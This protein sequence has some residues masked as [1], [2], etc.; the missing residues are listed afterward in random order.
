MDVNELI[1]RANSGDVE[2]EAE[3][4]RQFALKGDFAASIQWNQRAAS[5]GSG[6]AMLAL[7]SLYSNGNGVSAD[8]NEANK[9]LVRAADANNG[10]AIMVLSSNY[11]KG[12]DGFEYNPQ[13]A[14]YYIQKLASID[15]WTNSGRYALASYYENGIGVPQD[16]NMS[17]NIF[18]ELAN[19]GFA[20][21]QLMLAIKFAKGRGLQQDMDQASY[22]ANMA[23]DSSRTAGFSSK[24]EKVHSLANSLFDMEFEDQ[25]DDSSG[26]CYI[27]TAVYGSYDCSQVWV[28]RRFRD[29]KL[30]K[31]WYGKI[32]IKTYYAISPSLVKWFGSSPWF[33]NFWKPRLDEMVINLKNEGYDDTPYYD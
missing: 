21:A 4:G 2:A 29:Y 26:G 12:A 14:F 11:E 5:H 16:Y 33:I 9:W 23:L 1:Q 25:S 30:A 15:G 3:L 27:A 13:R 7:W 17:Y 19:E 6:A 22:W 31:S 18:L 28:L 8:K 10:A 20:D 24:I 32:F